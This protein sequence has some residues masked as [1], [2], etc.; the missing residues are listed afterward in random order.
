MGE[1]K[2]Q[3]GQSILS[4]FHNI[5]APPTHLRTHVDTHMGFFVD[6]ECVLERRNASQLRPVEIVGLQGLG[7][8]LDQVPAIKDNQYRVALL[9][10][11]FHEGLVSRQESGIVSLN[12][13]LLEARGYK[14]LCIRHDDL[15]PKADVVTKTK[16][17]IARLKMSLQ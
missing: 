8:P 13:R 15:T 12:R 9:V 16:Q 1:G 17:L 3:M 7:I 10:I 14:V 5:A 2:M 4:L 6:G 11:S